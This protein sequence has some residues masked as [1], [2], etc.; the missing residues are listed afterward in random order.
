MSDNIL[1]DK[2]IKLNTKKK[3]GIGLLGKIF[4]SSALRLEN[5]NA[6]FRKHI[7]LSLLSRTNTAILLL[8]FY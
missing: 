3:K 1:K 7:S 5:H 6:L 4:L 8:Y 2:I